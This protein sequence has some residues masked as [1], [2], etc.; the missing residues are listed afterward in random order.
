M[1]V[2]SKN[3]LLLT[4]TPRGYMVNLRI[5]N[6]PKQF[7]WLISGAVGILAL[8]G[9]LFFAQPKSADHTTMADNQNASSLNLQI[10]PQSYDFG[11]IS[12]KNGMVT[13]VF[14]IKNTKNEPILLSQLYTSCMCTNASIK[15]NGKDIGPFGM[16]GGHGGGGMKMLNE[17]FKAGD[18]AEVSVVFDPN[19][20][21]PSGIGVIERS[22]SLQSDKGEVASV[23]IKANVTP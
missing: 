19:A 3:Y 17:T 4:N 13:K 16:L 22:V 15:I 10:E 1:P 11:T 14:K 2:S 21:G 18:E 20:H 12:M 8:G 6:M 23:N 9:V 7:I 5:R